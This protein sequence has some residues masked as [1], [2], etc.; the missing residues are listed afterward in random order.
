MLDE[1]RLQDFANAEI[2][3]IERRRDARRAHFA[4]EFER[5]ARAWDYLYRKQLDASVRANMAWIYISEFAVAA[6]LLCVGAW[7]AGV[8][9]VL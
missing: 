8:A 6:T 4:S 7:L 3:K 2:D 1:T 9:S 5:N